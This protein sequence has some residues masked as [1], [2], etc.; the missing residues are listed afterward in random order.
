M[1]SKSLIG[2]AAIT[3]TVI[4]LI[5]R[6]LGFVREILF[7]NYY[8]TNL[9]YE[10]YLVA[11]IIPLT[12][13]TISIFFYQNYFIPNYAIVQN[14]CSEESGYFV[15]KT[16]LNSLIFSMLI[17]L[18]FILFSEQIIAFYAGKEI[19]N[20]KLK[21]LF[22]IFSLT[23]IPAILSSFLSAYLNSKGKF[24]SPAFSLLFINLVTI[25]SLLHFKSKNIIPIAVG[26]LVGSFIQLFYL[27]IKTDIKSF[28]QI[29][30]ANQKI[31]SKIKYSSVISI[32]LI[33]LIGQLYVV[34]DRYFYSKVDTGGI[35][36][37][38]Y[39]TSIFLLPVSIFT[40]SLTTAIMPRISELSVKGEVKEMSELIN[41]LFSLSF[42]FFIPFITIFLLQGN[43]VIRLF[44]QRGNF[45]YISTQ[46]TYEVLFYLSLSLI[47][48]VMYSF[49]NKFLYSFQKITFLLFLTISV[50]SLKFL[51]NYLL[52]NSL[53]Q[54]GL[55]ISTSISYTIFF[56]FAFIKVKSKLKINFEP[57]IFSSFLFYL[58]N[59]LFSYFIATV[60]VFT[61]NPN[62]IFFD[63]FS[64]IIFLVFYY[65]NNQI[66][67]DENQ[68]L[69]L[70]QLKIL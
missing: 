5:I 25:I 15:K 30:K 36:S 51:M 49:F 61:L 48:Y 39:A 31:L 9:E 70:N 67:R 46:M 26:Y 24:G 47:F 20:T 58:L 42:L 65:L 10:I 68:I 28:I 11:S 33:E 38:N 1:I 35:A 69:I 18:V 22:S 13:N 60:I 7:A 2:K 40:I 55:A 16:F 3:I 6:V 53:K 17:S 52:V 27:L 8:G 45:D 4:S 37:L 32:L 14:D 12:I 63:L 56:L 19:L 41:K 29:K 23:I 66:F 50:L 43:Q 21:L 59:A 57:K 62:T 44:F 64:I 54:N 34:T